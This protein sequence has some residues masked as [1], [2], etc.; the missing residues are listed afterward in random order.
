[1]K[2]VLCFTDYRKIYYAETSKSV[3]VIGEPVKNRVLWFMIT[4]KIKMNK[5]PFYFRKF[6]DLYL[7][8]L[9]NSMSFLERQIL[10]QFYINLQYNTKGNAS[11]S[12]ESFYRQ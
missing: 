11:S 2:K 9:A 1:M 5:C 8:R 6:F 7:Q 4:L 10:R 12:T 3:K